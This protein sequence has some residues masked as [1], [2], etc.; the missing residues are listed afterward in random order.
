MWIRRTDYEVTSRSL[1]YNNERS[2]LLI[3]AEEGTDRAWEVTAETDDPLLRLN[4]HKV[5][6]KAWNDN[7]WNEIL[8]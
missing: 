6:G 8:F 5:S 3:S 1:Q 4:G 7:V 2:L